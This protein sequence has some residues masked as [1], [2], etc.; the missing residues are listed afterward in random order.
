[1]ASRSDA[2]RVL[3][4]GC[5]GSPVVTS[6]MP[7]RTLATRS[8]MPSTPAAVRPDAT[9]VGPRR[10][11]RSA[12]DYVIHL[13]ALSFVGSMT[14]RA[15]TR[16]TRLARRTAG[17]PRRVEGEP[18][19]VVIASSANVYATRRW[20]RSRKRP[21]CTGQSLR[22]QQACDGNDGPDLR[23]PAFHRHDAPFNYTGVGQSVNFL[24]RNWWRTSR[25]RRAFVELGNSMSCAISLTYGR[26]P[27]PICDCL[28]RTFRKA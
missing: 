18:T 11:E 20:S 3:V 19:A 10:G 25:Q 27:R 12:P 21:S 8:L 5:T 22:G 14:H 6:P 4:T 24:C 9:G 23:R 28:R 15:S 1:V 13:A 26:W 17:G 2:A 7:S 16:S